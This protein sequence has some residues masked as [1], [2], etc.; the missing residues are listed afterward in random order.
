M[1]MN[2]YQKFVNI[3]KPLLITGETGTGKSFLA[4]EIFHHSIINKNK[5]LT[6]HLAS[7]KEDLLESELYGHKKGAFTGAV[8]NKAGYLKEASGGTLF[9]DEV[10][11]LSLEGQKKLLY[12]LEEG[13]FSPVGD[14]IIYNLNARLIFATN[15]DL[16]QMVLAKE[17]REDLYFRLM[18]F[19]IELQ[20]INQDMIKLKNLILNCFERIKTEQCKKDLIISKPLMDLFLHHPWSGNYRELKNVMEYMVTISEKQIL[21]VEMIPHWFNSS[22][23]KS[24][25]IDEKKFTENVSE[26]YWEALENFEANYLRYILEKNAGKVNETARKI[27]IS[28]AAL[29][30]KAKKYN[31]NTLKLR[32][33]A[34]TNEIK[35]LAA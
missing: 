20:P 18:I 1:E 25:Q 2:I 33:D 10:G 35:D 16:Y 28:K 14:T 15:K 11:E 7:I 6:L 4:K 3:K 17:F 27:G 23:R 29:I 8:E 34:S 32:A 13:K 9:I 5:F 24:N 31:I 30:Y 21:E 22:Q 19:N 26:N 12:L